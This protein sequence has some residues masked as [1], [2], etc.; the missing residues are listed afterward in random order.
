MQNQKIK[1]WQHNNKGSKR[2]DLGHYVR[3]TWEANIARLFKLFG[4]NYIYEPQ[5]FKFPVKKGN[6][7]YTPDFYL[8]EYNLYIEVK[9]YMYFSSRVKL[10]RMFRYYSN[11]KLL[12][13]SKNCYKLLES[14]YS[15]LIEEWEYEKQ[16]TKKLSDLKNQAGDNFSLNRDNFIQIF[17]SFQNEEVKKLYEPSKRSSRQSTERI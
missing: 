15:F 2:P 16:K 12:I 10:K 3:S 8:P 1:T 4:I 7:A 11:L 6:T 5:T 17:Q 13:L 14:Q 9:G